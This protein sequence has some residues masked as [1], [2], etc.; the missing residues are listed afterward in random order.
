MPEIASQRPAAAERAALVRCHVDEPAD[1]AE[2]DAIG[3]VC[4]GWAFAEGGALRAVRL[5]AGGLSVEGPYGSPRP[6]VLAAFPGLPDD[7]VGWQLHAVF[8]PGELEIAVEFQLA[9]GAWA[10][11]TRRRLRVARARR[12]R[13]MPGYENIAL[14]PRQMPLHALHPPRALRADEFPQRPSRSGSLTRVSIVTPN[15]N[16]GWALETCLD[17]VLES[18]GDGS[19]ASS[20]FA[21]GHLQAHAATPLDLEYVVQDGC[22]SDRSL[23]LIRRRHT[24]IDYW[25]SIPDSGQTDALQRGF[26][27]TTGGPRDVMAWI[28]A[29]DF[30]LPGA[31]RYVAAYFARHPEIDVIYGHRLLVDRDGREIG[32]W[33]LPRHDP[34][35]LRLYDIVPQETLFWR[36]RV[37][38]RV[39]GLRR[40]F[41]FAMDWDLFLRFMATGAKIARV[42]YFLAAFR[43]HGAQKTRSQLATVGEQEI[44]QLH[45]RTFGRPLTQEELLSSRPLA[46]YLR[47][48]AWIETL[49]RLGYRAG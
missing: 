30:Y 37:W 34:A 1:G 44:A 48:S 3:L 8:P 46:R 24:A 13:W 25:E 42:P 12:P 47:R 40:E 49:W 19:E 43:L 32:R 29:D 5:V 36:R 41:G 4:R 10:P 38:E 28:N 18:R 23:E 39:G 9:S 35:V 45:R 11:G 31:L 16:Q 22:S 33:F 26:A 14:L 2:V 6:D 15:L 27:K 20:R 7:R 17:A 21:A